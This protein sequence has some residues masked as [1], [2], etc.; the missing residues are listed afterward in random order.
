MV[1]LVITVDS[2]GIKIFALS[3]QSCTFS[4]FS[5]LRSAHRILRSNSL[6]ISTVAIVERD[7]VALLDDTTN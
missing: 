4:Y 5:V 3:G 7:M 1:R 2:C 6:T